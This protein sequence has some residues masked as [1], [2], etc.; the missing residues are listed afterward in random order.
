MIIVI[1]CRTSLIIKALDIM[2]G[3]GKKKNGKHQ[4]H[5]M[6]QYNRNTNVIGLDPGRSDLFVTT[7]SLDNSTSCSNKEWRH[8]SGANRHLRKKKFWLKKEPFLSLVQNQLPPRGVADVYEFRDHL[9]ELVAHQHDLLKF[10]NLPK[11]R[12]LRLHTYMKKQKAYNTICNRILS[13]SPNQPPNF[14]SIV[15]FG[16]AGFSSSSRGYASAPV[17]G[18]RRELSKRCSVVLVDEFKT[19]Q[20]CSGCQEKFHEHQRF[21]KLRACKRCHKLWNRDVNASRNI[22]DIFMYM[23]RMG[24]ERPRIFRRRPTNNVTM[25]DVGQEEVEDEE[26]DD[27]EGEEM[28]DDDEEED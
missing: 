7:N 21:W 6:P 15:A 9:F 28:D 17:K 27:D 14:S 22:R 1:N 16:A 8:I 25:S 23:H 20:V 13:P 5:T 3:S 2:E 26:M 10:Y 4:F 11:H 19:S 12:R 24:G 18:L